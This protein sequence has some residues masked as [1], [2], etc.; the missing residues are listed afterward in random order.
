MIMKTTTLAT[1]ALLL[2]PT[3]PSAQ[4][5]TGS[6]VFRSPQ[7]PVALSLQQTA[8]GQLNGALNGA[9]GSVLRLQGVVQDGRATGQIRTGDGVGW[10]AAGFNGP[11]LVL[12]VAEIDPATGQ[13]DLERSW[14]LEFTRTGGAAPPPAGTGPATPSPTPA[15]PAPGAAP[16]PFGQPDGSQLAREWREMLSGAK[17]TR[18]SSYS[19]ST[20]G[21]GG[22]SEHWEA[23]LCSDRTMH[24]RDNS[25]TS[26][27]DVGAYSARQG[28]AAGQWQVITQG[29]RAF[30]ATQFE[31]QP[32]RYGELTF[33]QA[34]RATYLDGKRFYITR[35]DNHVCR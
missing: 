2:W 31:G 16:D 33:N 18:I 6:Y 34:Q 9:D 17:L 4:D 21:G 28:G 10:F 14:S 12:I 20:A 32:V 13:P 23:F 30:L 11:A 15:A 29:D 27:G 26:M 35:N 25:V 24:F 19:S 8:Q 1:L 3:I 5:L 22:Y 7:G